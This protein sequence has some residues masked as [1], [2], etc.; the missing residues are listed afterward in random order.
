MTASNGRSW[1]KS[2]LTGSMTHMKSGAKAQMKRCLILPQTVKHSE[3]YQSKY[4]NCKNGVWKMALNLTAAQEPG[5]R[6]NL[7]N[8]EMRRNKD[9]ASK[10]VVRSWI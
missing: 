2:T 8:R 5:T 3:K 7:A 4:Q 1:Q 6:Q 10:P 9:E